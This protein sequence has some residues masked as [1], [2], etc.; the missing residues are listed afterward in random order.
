MTLDEYLAS[1]E[2]AAQR[3]EFLDGELFAMSGG[4][5]AHDSLALAVA[6]EL[7]A[8]LRGKPC[9]AQASNLRVKSAATGLYTYPDALVHCGPVFEDAKETTLLNPRVIVEVLS[10][11]T[12]AYDRG[13][14]FRH[15]RAIPSVAEY[16]LVSATDRRVEIYARRERTWELSIREAGQEI[17]LASIDVRLALDAIY[18]GVALD[19]RPT[20]LPERST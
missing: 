6:A 5:R 2:T 9:A 4:T 10:A 12:E 11:G 18:E 7:R 15:Y 19:P 20:S 16:V 13:E 17:E 8:A 14:K 1:E 3:H